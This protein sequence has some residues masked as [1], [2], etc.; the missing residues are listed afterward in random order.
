MRSLILTLIAFLATTFLMAQEPVWIFFTDKGPDVACLLENPEN[1]LS[2]AAL[3]RR[4]H[5]HIPFTVQDLPLYQPYMD[6]LGALAGKPLGSS[7]WLNAVAVNINPR[8]KN[9]ILTLSFVKGV[10]KV[11][12]GKLMEANDP[13]KEFQLQPQNIIPIPGYGQA[14]LQ[15]TMLKIEGLHQKGFS[16]E[17]VKIAIMDAGFRGVDKIEAF[18]SVRSSGRILATYDF[19]DKDTFVYDYDVHG[20]QVM[21]VIGA[22]MPDQLI[23]TAPKASF[24]L[25]RTENRFSETRQEEYNWVQAME[26]ADSLGADVIHTSL[27]YSVFDSQEESY[28][29]ENM[30]GNTAITTLAA[31]M[32][33]RRG[34]IVTASAGNERMNSWEKIVAPCDGDSVLCIGSIDRHGNLS[35]FSSIG[36]SADG[37]VKPDVVAMG[38]RTMAT[39]SSNRIYGVNGT[40]FSAPL[41]A[42]VVAC[43][44]QAHPQRSNIDII[45]AVRLSGDQY[46]LPDEKYGYGIPNAVFADS[47]LANVED[48]STVKISMEEKPF[49]GKKPEVAEIKPKPKAEPQKKDQ[50][51]FTVN[52]QTDIELEPKK[53]IISTKD[54]QAQIQTY[55]LY[56]GNQKVILNS[57]LISESLDE[58]TIRT[59]HLLK[60]NDYYLE[61]TT[62]AFTERI[63]IILE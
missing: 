12:K 41:V 37:R 5:N 30:D 1:Y 11:A 53:L 54:S 39:S 50:V 23:G 28:K 40:S 20:T 13:P 21:S 24:M 45:Q 3:E 2:Q 19:V 49:R 43:L 34:I 60:G 38:S 27:G 10:R 61:I 8:V 32:A 9:E 15:N 57:K 26:M 14:E 52:P 56:K 46:A 31:E 17:G 6:E 4:E 55:T 47:L 33:A 58:I 63:P 29:Y 62:D 59:K 36:P 22:N 42:G 18:D 35:S 48:L 7:R 16:G 44:R 25:F 51:T